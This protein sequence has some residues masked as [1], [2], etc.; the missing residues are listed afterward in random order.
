MS[1][2]TP[3]RISGKALAEIAAIDAGFLYLAVLLHAR[4]RPGARAA[5]ENSIYVPSAAAEAEQVAP[6]RGV[7]SEAR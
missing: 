5:D 3:G 2:P 6:A 4:S 1:S 7:A